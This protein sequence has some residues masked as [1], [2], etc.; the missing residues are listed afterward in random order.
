VGVDLASLTRDPGDEHVCALAIAG[1][2]DLL[3]THDRGY[4][5]EGLAA[6]G[7]SVMRPDAFLVELLATDERALVRI[8]RRQAQSWGARFADPLSELLAAFERAGARQFAARLRP[9]V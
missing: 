8:V 9:L 1:A 6:Y 3:F 4:L 7:V 5:Q 2:A